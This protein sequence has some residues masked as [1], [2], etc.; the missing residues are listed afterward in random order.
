M[1]SHRTIPAL[2]FGQPC[3]FGQRCL[4]GSRSLLTGAALAMLASLHAPP[5]AAAPPEQGPPADH[6]EARTSPPS[7]ERQ[8]AEQARREG[9]SPSGAERERDAV[10]PHPEAQ[11]AEAQ[12]RVTAQR[13]QNQQDAARRTR[14]EGRKSPEGEGEGEGDRARPSPEARRNRPA[15]AESPRE[16]EYRDSRGKDFRVPTSDRVRVITQAHAPA[17]RAAFTGAAL[18]GCP[19]GIADKYQGCTIPV[20]THPPEK[21][22]HDPGWFARD[23]ADDTRYRYTDGYLL[24]L[25]AE[26]RAEG[27][28]D[29]GNGVVGYI[30]LLGG[31]LSVGRAW[32][33]TYRPVALPGYYTGYYGLGGDGAY[34]FYDNTIYRV[35]AADAAITGIAAL[36]LGNDIA[37]GRTMPTGY[38]VYN[39]PTAYRDQ[40]PDGPDAL[41]RYS[42]G[43]IYQLDPATRL[44]RAAIELLA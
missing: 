44:V 4:F 21:A 5:L 37:I 14:D 22:W 35:N 17:A 26:N 3:L 16:S 15:P 43:Y 12:N 20:R 11:N 2:P 39:L 19:A 40:Y 13:E 23:F 25:G 32:P 36:L 8:H 33:G 7:A 18:T 34:R 31:A 6:P 41:Y 28:G 9:P 29:V 24:R 10:A 30:P 27:G 42:D 38:D 1:P